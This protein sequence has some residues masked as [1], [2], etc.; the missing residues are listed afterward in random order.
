MHTAWPASMS[1]VSQRPSGAGVTPPAPEVAV[2]S[3]GLAEVLLNFTIAPTAIVAVVGAKAN[4]G[5]AAAMSVVPDA[6]HVTTTAA[7]PA[8]FPASVLP[9]VPAVPA[10]P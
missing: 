10:V 7:A 5:P 3:I 2:C 9:P 6:G 1:P 4:G 8:S